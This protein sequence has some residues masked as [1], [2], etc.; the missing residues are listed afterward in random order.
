MIFSNH[1][2]FIGLGQICFWNKSKSVL[3]SYLTYTLKFLLFILVWI[4]IKIKI[5]HRNN[6]S[7]KG[8]VCNQCKVLYPWICIRN[9]IFKLKND[10]RRFDDLVPLETYLSLWGIFIIFCINLTKIENWF[11]KACR[12]KAHFANRIFDDL[13]K[14]FIPLWYLKVSYI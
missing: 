12:M 8:C 7:K 3:K 13:H 4:G 2:H 6:L 9:I 11:K 1:F 14:R 10:M 5:L